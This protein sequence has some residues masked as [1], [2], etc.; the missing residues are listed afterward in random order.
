MAGIDKAPVSPPSDDNSDCVDDDHLFDEDD[1]SIT[2][3][4]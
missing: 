3:T 4:F 2:F 1:D